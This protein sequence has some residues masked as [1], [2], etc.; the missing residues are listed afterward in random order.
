MRLYRGLSIILAVSIAVTIYSVVI[1]LY[2]GDPIE[3]YGKMFRNAFLD[4]YGL[5]ETL[6]LAASLGII[7]LGLS[8]VFRAGI[9]N[10]GAE[11][12]Y[13]LGGLAAGY[14]V[15]VLGLGHLGPVAPLLIG[16]L[17]GGLYAALPGILRWRLGVNEVLTTLML[18]YV[19][20]YLLYYVVYGVWRD[21]E[22]GFP[23]TQEIPAYYRLPDIGGVVGG[24]IIMVL[25]APILH[26]LLF[27]TR[28]GF[29]LRVYG[30]NREAAEYAGYNRMAIIVGGLFI[31]G[32]LSGLAGSGDLLGSYY[33][34]MPRFSSGL[35]YTG[36]IVALL[37]SNHPLIVPI[38]SILFAGFLYGSYTLAIVADIPTEATY[39]MTGL[40][41][42]LLVTS[43]Y[44]ERWVGWLVKRL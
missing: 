6:R 23:V 10:I 19:G 28:Y 18:N 17:A 40:L 8:I 13:I 43:Q 15:Y 16:G 35:G 1:I 44:L 31:S 37:A 27:H 41:L 20:L 24:L 7:S 11:G 9:W 39:L 38:A 29:T 22:T 42:A 5:R 3:A 21:P 12:Q 2:G 26:Y 33:R 4:P 30:L 34:L 14:V 36:I 25:L 32:V